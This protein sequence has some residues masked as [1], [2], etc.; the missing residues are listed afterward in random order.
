MFTRR[1][2]GISSSK[3]V[4]FN[5]GGPGNF[6]ASDGGTGLILVNFPQSLVGDT[7]DTIVMAS[8]KF[9]SSTG[10][11]PYYL[12]YQSVTTTGVT[13]ALYDSTGVLTNPL[14]GA[15]IMCEVVADFG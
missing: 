8:F 3:S 13:L 2:C 15:V 10:T 6:T 14:P 12:R 5:D 1:V 7:A 11:T 9:S 4:T